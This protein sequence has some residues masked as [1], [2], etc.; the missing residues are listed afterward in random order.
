MPERN[1]IIKRTEWACRLTATLG[2]QFLALSLSFGSL[3]GEATPGILLI[4][5]EDVQQDEL[6]LFQQDFRPGDTACLSWKE[7]TSARLQSA[8]AVALIRPRAADL[9]G[10]EAAARRELVSPKHG[11]FLIGLPTD[12][13]ELRAL[14]DFMPERLPGAAVAHPAT[15]LFHSQWIWREPPIGDYY[16]RKTFDLPSNFKN[17]FICLAADGV[18]EL[19]LNGKHIG[20][21][22][23]WTD[24]ARFD[25][26]G[27]AKPGR[28]VICIQGNNTD[29]PGGLLASLY[30]TDRNEK[31][32][33]SLGTDDTWKASIEPPPVPWL[34]SAYDDGQWPKANVVCTYSEGS[35]GDSVVLDS[36]PIEVT[37]PAGAL[38]GEIGRRIQVDHWSPVFSADPKSIVL[39]KQ[40]GAPVAV[41]RDDASGRSVSTLEYLPLRAVYESNRADLQMDPVYAEF[42]RSSVQWLCR[43]TPPP[44]LSTQTNV[45]TL[46]TTARSTTAENRFLMVVQLS[47]IPGK[48]WCPPR[49]MLDLKAFVDEIT[50]DG[51][52]ALQVGYPVLSKGWQRYVAAY[53]QQKG[54][55]LINRGF[56]TTELFT[57]E[58]PAAVSVYSP[59]Y[60]SAVRNSLEAFKADFP[61]GVR[62]DQIYPYMDEPFHIGSS[63]FDL[64]AEARSAFHK[65]LGYELPSDANAIKDPKVVLDVLNFHSE[66]FPAGWRQVYQELKKQFPDARIAITHDSHNTFGAA[67]E[68]HAGIAVDDVFHWGADFADAFDFDIYPYFDTDYRTGLALEIGKPRLSQ[69]HYG[70]AQMRN[71]TYTHNKPLGF[72]VGTLNAQW[73]KITPAMHEFWWEPREMIY[74]AVANGCDYLITGCGAPQD[75][76]QWREMGKTLRELQVIAPVLKRTR[77]AKAQACFLFPRTQHL[78]LQKDCWNNGVVFELFRRAFGELDILHEDQIVDSRLNGYKVL[79]LSDV[80]LLPNAVSER[81]ASFVRNG[82]L[83]I[84]DK[85]P[86]LNERKEPSRVIAD[87]RREAGQQRMLL[88]PGSLLDAYLDTWKKNDPAGRQ[89]L[90]ATIRNFCLQGNAVPT[91]YSSNPDI[92]ATVRCSPD[93]LL[94]FIINHES[95][96]DKTRV[97][98]NHLPLATN[99]V[100]D[101]GSGQP[102]A[103]RHTP[104][105]LALD[106]SVPLGTTR[107]LT[108]LGEGQDQTKSLTALALGL[109]VPS[110]PAK[111]QSQL[112]GETGAK[113]LPQPP[114]TGT[115]ATN[116]LLRL[117]TLNVNRE[118]AADAH[119]I[120][121]PSGKTIL[122]D[123][124]WPP[125]GDGANVVLAFLKR[126]GIRQI[127]WMMASHPHNDHIG[128]MPEI[129]LSP[130]VKVKALLWSLPPPEKIKKLDSESVQ[131][132][133]EWT[134]KVRQACTQRGVPIREIKEGQVIDFGDGIQGHI[135]AAADPGFDCP[136]YVNNNS[137]VMR[138]TFGKFSEM[139]C[140]DAGFEEEARI[141]SRTKD[142][143]SDIWKIGHHAGAGSTSEAWAKAI[144]AKIGIAPMPKYL[145]EDERGLRVWRQLLPT[146]IKIYRT[147]EHGHIE[148]QTD[149]TRFWLETERP[150]SPAGRTM[151]DTGQTGRS[152]F[153]RLKACS[154]TA[155]PRSRRREEAS[156]APKTRT[157]VR[158]LSSAATISKYTLSH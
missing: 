37:A 22:G 24:A 13:K 31:I 86:T 154:R 84:A 45:P 147:W 95:R 16:V 152:E 158:L 87:L 11:L 131:E 156:F 79:V 36:E 148:A 53:A 94:V 8:S 109:A 135:L 30:V 141:M 122:L 14:S 149:G 51:F 96:D 35:W 129:L 69:V 23:A 115:I 125:P 65:R 28:N 100:V 139:F 62:L 5:H 10:L 29:G 107:V 91:V 41:A 59:Q 26:S 144:N 82:G 64:S 118:G 52:A 110:V 56:G 112:P 2:V 102:V 105:G 40:W 137:I 27:V 9:Q 132:C 15:K 120:I 114:P 74:T 92:E 61:E 155:T 6:E 71:L 1:V 145:S 81:I 76:R 50:S 111:N 126:E 18:G 119:L 153:V 44:A 42:I 104:E 90:S 58:S 97:V 70:L 43:A 116:R 46:T 25:A 124:G 33:L 17:V 101:A 83:L 150:S 93:A 39:L 128:G 34:G 19:F 80:E 55:K 38:L 133:E 138:L 117:I 48:S 49:S 136:N 47:S 99:R 54:L 127:D 106:L 89:K 113:Y 66:S 60:T 32:I 73:F 108:G 85:L 134:S 21:S 78:L 146:G 20:A 77:K 123:A 142:L 12:P 88:F 67:V 72:W 130:E 63:G 68:G 57:R 75:E 7:V 4:S 3:A 157:R 143:A 121:T 98:L 103:T 140:G 151:S